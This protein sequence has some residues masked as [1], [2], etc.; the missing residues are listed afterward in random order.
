MRYFLSNREVDII[1]KIVSRQTLFLNIDIQILGKV[2]QFIEFDC[3]RPWSVLI[4]LSWYNNLN[5]KIYKYKIVK[6][7]SLC[8]MEIHSYYK[9]TT[10]NDSIFYKYCGYRIV[11][12]CYFIMDFILQSFFSTSNTFLIRAKIW[13]FGNLRHCCEC[14]DKR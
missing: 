14:F 8:L 13:K 3:T 2:F 5:I 4:T 9:I 6:C 7:L 12:C 1:E 11:W 10:K